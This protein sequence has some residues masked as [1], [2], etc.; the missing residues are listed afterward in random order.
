MQTLSDFGLELYIVSYGIFGMLLVGIFII[1]KI[2]QENRLPITFIIIITFIHY[3]FTAYA[4]GSLI[5][6]Y[7]LS[8]RVNTYVTRPVLLN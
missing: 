1:S 4:L 3:P 8:L 7:V 6:G 2:N 5:L